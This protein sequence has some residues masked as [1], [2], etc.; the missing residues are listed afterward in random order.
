MGFAPSRFSIPS[1]T[2]PLVRIVLVLMHGALLATL[3]VPRCIRVPRASRRNFCVGAVVSLL[4]EH[5]SQHAGEDCSH[6]KEAACTLRVVACF[7]PS[8]ARGTNDFQR[9]HV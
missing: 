4:P 3:F 7:T 9:M 6:S 8:E 5:A 2:L 1:R